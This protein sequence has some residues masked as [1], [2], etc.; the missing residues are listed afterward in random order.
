MHVR[1]TPFRS[2]TARCLR[3]HPAP[4]KRVVPNEFNSCAR[5]WAVLCRAGSVLCGQVE[6]TP[7]HP[8]HPA[9]P[10]DLV[11]HC[12]ILPSPL[13][14]F[15]SAPLAPPFLPSPAPIYRHLAV[16][17]TLHMYICNIYKNT[18]F[19]TG[20]LPLRR[21]RLGSRKDDRSRPYRPF[22]PSNRKD[23]SS[24][25]HR[26]P[27]QKKKGG[28][29]D[30]LPDES[31]RRRPG[32]RARCPSPVTRGDARSNA[33]ADSPRRTPPVA[34]GVSAPRPARPATPP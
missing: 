24:A 25:G 22:G 34:R 19:R 11:P 9:P 6:A 23:E 2:Y 33:L 20:R 10:T 3:G 31:I 18:T 21:C 26:V 13:L 8:I 7:P 4:Q 30:P 16:I 15:P 29:L 32:T 27:D 28:F 5:G 17:G 1:R 12:P 14:P